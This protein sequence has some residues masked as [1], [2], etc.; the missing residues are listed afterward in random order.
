[1]I[2]DQPQGYGLVTIV[3]HW[4]S[5]GSIIFLFALGL[6]MTSLGYYDEWYHKGP[7]V[8]V[9]VGLILFVLMSVRLLWRLLSRSP[10]PLPEHTRLIRLASSAVKVVLY[11][12]VFTVMATGYL[13]TTAEGSA[14]EIFGW[15][16]FP[17][18]LE[19]EPGNVDLAGTVHWLLAWAIIVF[20]SL[21][22]LAALG[23]HFVLKDDTLKRIVRPV[24]NQ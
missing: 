20:A 5:A 8:H 17:V 15:V 3:L 9:S 19:L 1:M 14:P 6:Y 21:H 7:D 10:N 4:V 18:L 23:H 12:L 16:S 11:A 22:A 2:K 13:I 24:K